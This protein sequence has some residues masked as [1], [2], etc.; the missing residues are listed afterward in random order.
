[1]V[2]VLTVG[3]LLVVHYGVHPLPVEVMK[4]SF[5]DRP[6]EIGAVAYRRFFGAIEDKGRVVVGIPPEPDWYREILV[7][8]LKGAA[9]E[10]HAFDTIVMEEQMPALDLTGLPPTEVIRLHTN[11]STQAELVEALNR[12][13]EAKKRTLVY[14]PSVF[15]SHLLKQSPVVRVEPLLGQGLMSITVVPL[16]L[17]AD[18]EYLVEPPCMGSERDTTNTSALGCEVLQSGRALY[19]KKIS[20]D[21][22]VAIMNAPFGDDFVLMVSQAGQD[23]ADAATANKDIRMSPPAAAAAPGM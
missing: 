15:T 2:A 17:R 14:M 10:K 23:K 3:T 1:M 12:L 8:F 16:A 4:P 5:F 6:Q 19:R 18:Q 9:T 7:G 13:A 20:Q 11:T 22:W 21:R